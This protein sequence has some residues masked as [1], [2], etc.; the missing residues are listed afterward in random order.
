MYGSL[1]ALAMQI[2]N[3]SEEEQKAQISEAVSKRQVDL[4]PLVPTMKECVLSVCDNGKAVLTADNGTT[5]VARELTNAE[6]FRLSQVLGDANLTHI[7][8]AFDGNLKDF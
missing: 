3:K 7:A 6:F 8:A 2:D 1:L 5:K 4:K